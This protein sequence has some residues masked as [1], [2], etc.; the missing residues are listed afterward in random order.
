MATRILH[1]ILA[2]LLLISSTGFTVS[3][4]RCGGHLVSVALF[5]EATNCY[6]D[7]VEA[8]SCE[9]TELTTSNCKRGCCQDSKD[10]FK[11]DIDEQQTVFDYQ[12]SLPQVTVTQ[13]EFLPLL[14][15]VT[16]QV[17]VIFPP[18]PPPDI[19]RDIAV[20]FQIFRL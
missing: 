5:A 12:L 13:R 3:S 11:A 1:I 20:F 10:Y 4:H 17:A 7:T 9:R 2:F 15:P 19:I 16:A 14:M 18:F 8:T 6:G